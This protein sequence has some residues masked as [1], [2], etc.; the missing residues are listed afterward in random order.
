MTAQAQVKTENENPMAKFDAPVLKSMGARDLTEAATAFLPTTMGEAMELA[1]LMAASNFVPP[2]L[3]GKA[4][5]CL[6][7]VMQSSRWEMDPFAVANK[8]FFVNDRMAYEAQLVVAVVN[9]RAPLVG[10]LSYTYEGDG[11]G[12]ACIVSGRLR[13][14]DEVKTVCQNIST[15]TTRNSPLWKSSPEQQLGYYT[16]RLW[17]RRH[18]P[19]VL[20]GVY[21]EDEL[22]DPAALEEGAD[23]TYRPAPARPQRRDYGASQQS[24]AEA[25]I[26]D[27]STA[28]DEA[29]ETWEFVNA[30]GE[31][32]TFSDQTEFLLELNNAIQACADRKALQTIE[33]NNREVIAGLAN[34]LRLDIAAAIDEVGKRI[35]LGALGQAG[36]KRR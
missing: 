2:H 21:T 23:G 7:V 25:E 1:K 12:L 30:W 5:D 32:V 36:A 10:R 17:A 11:N 14:D 9:T 6:A 29:A 18:C 3:R 20:L 34:D 4:G 22:R 26:A 8:T 35:D 16:A 33:E 28:E 27:E 13:G 24:V 19:E 31:S 15:I